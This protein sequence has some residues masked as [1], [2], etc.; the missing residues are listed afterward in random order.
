[1]VKIAR[2]PLPRTWTTF[3]ILSAI[4]SI[5]I[6]YWPPHIAS[7]WPI[8]ALVIWLVAGLVVLEAREIRSR[9]AI[10]TMI[11]MTIV[12]IGI[13]MFAPKIVGFPLQDKP[14]PSTP[15]IT[16]STHTTWKMEPSDYG[17][18]RWFANGLAEIKDSK[19]NA[20]AALA[21]NAWLEKVKTDPNLLAGAVKYLLARDTDKTTLVDK[22]GWATDKAAQLVSEL[23]LTLGQAKVVAADAPSTGY[24]SGVE[25]NTVVGSATAGI[26]GDRKAV[27]VTLPDGEVIWI[28]GRC[29]NIVTKGSPPVPPGKT[30]QPPI[31]TPPP[32]PPTLTPKSSNPNDY[33]RPGTDN[34]T[35]SGTGIK[36]KVPT[37]TTPAKSK[38]P[39]V[40]TQ[41][42]SSS[43][44][45]DTPTNRPGTETGI[46]AHGATPT[47]V[48]P[49][50]PA[51]ETGVNPSNGSSNNTDPTNPF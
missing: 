35:D 43:G 33:Q 7:P 25:N 22:D 38:P 32:G 21:A 49:T 14:S 18:N 47:P 48:N 30:D 40:Q 8:V 19:T 23:E 16:T 51:P 11:I 42:K 13:A 1:M 31:V 29:G 28:M 34:T 10:G 37:V 39:V 46:I 6:G 12:L 9:R 17:N 20:E 4:L 24:N 3:V 26:N 27:Q 2:R 36:P 50:L 5:I 41:K 15:A 44:V 45:V